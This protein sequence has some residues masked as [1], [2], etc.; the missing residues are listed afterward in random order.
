MM[1][2]ASRSPIFEKH[3][4]Q[5]LDLQNLKMK[6]HLFVVLSLLFSLAAQAQVI[7]IATARL[8]DTGTV[9]TVSGTVTNGAELGAIRYFQD[10]TGGMAA[11]GGI[12]TIKRGDSIIVTGKMVTYNNLLEIQPVTSIQ[13]IARNKPLPAPKIV[14][15][16]QLADSLEG[17]LVTYKNVNFALTGNFAAAKNYDI[18]LGATKTVVRSG[19]AA[20]NI[21]GAL[22]PSSTVNVTGILSQFCSSPVLACATGYQTLLRD[23]AD[24]EFQSIALTEGLTATNV[25]TTSFNVNWQTNFTGTTVIYYGTT[26]A[27]GQTKTVAGSSTAHI[28]PLTGLSPATVYYVQGES[29]GGG[30]VVKSPITSFVTASVSTGEMRVYFNRSVDTTFR[31]GTAKP[32]ATTGQRCVSELIA[33]IAAATQ[34]IDVAM[35]SS[36]EIAIKDALKAAAARGVRVRYIADKSALNAI[37]SDTTALGFRF[38]KSTNPDLMHNKFFIFDA[39]SVDKAWLSAGS[40]NNS[41]GQLYTDPNNMIMIQDQALARVYTVEFEEMWGSTTALPNAANAKYG[42]NKSRNTPKN[43]IIGGGKNIEVYFSPTDGTTAGIV[44][45][46]DSANTDLE[47]AL[48]IHT[49]NETGT[50]IY[51]AKR[52]GVNARGIVNVDTATTGDEY[53]YLLRNGVQM[54]LYNDGSIFHHKYCLVDAKNAASN[55]TLLTGSHNWSATAE[56]KNDENLLIIHDASIVNIYLQEFEARW[57]EAA[58]V[59]VKEVKIDGFEAMIFPN[60][61]TN[62][63]NIKLNSQTQRDVSITLLNSIGQ[64]I[65]TRI[66]RNL[67]GESTLN[68]PLNNLP[69]GQ[70]FMSFWVDGKMMTKA[71]QVVR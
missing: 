16:A 51:N 70:Y 6:K 71:L 66:L 21:V 1:Q 17:Q 15:F 62:E 38:E 35:Y 9:I 43:V 56:T 27:L 58:R 42:P 57:K 44:N 33:R 13:V 18:T 20:S 55:P 11:F 26:P 36:G 5:F 39:G 45:E 31:I 4:L 53:T 22:I 14:L 30:A 19:P 12:D 28:V 59:D 64:A 7:S 60:P 40:M 46:I 34:T 10:K 3:F 69:A 48:L 8:R 61:A 68:F 2:K 41:T 65:E 23:T 67:S 63:T 52:R 50:A 49:A 37:F 29:A 25:T 47:F 24:I 54:R 32:L